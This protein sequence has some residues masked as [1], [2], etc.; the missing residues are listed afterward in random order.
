[1]TRTDTKQELIHK[2][3]EE[4]HASE[5]LVADMYDHTM[6]N[7]S[8]QARIRDYLPLMV[9]RRVRQEIKDSQNASRDKDRQ[10]AIPPAMTH[11]DV[12]H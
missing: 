8:A 12:V 2:I 4:Y 7:L 10:D 9:A 5:A 6:E 3:A 1:M 11:Q